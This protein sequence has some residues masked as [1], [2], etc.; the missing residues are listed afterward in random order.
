MGEAWNDPQLRGRV[1]T[2]DYEVDFGSVIPS[3][4]A[5]ADFPDIIALL[6][7]RRLLFCQARDLKAPDAASLAAR[8]RQV[9]KTADK[10]SVKLVPDRALD[11][12]LLL[13][14]LREGEKP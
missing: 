14:W 10:S 2:G 7:P 8:F 3:A 6:T 11:A 9:T 4:L 12:T 1:N 13:D 5:V